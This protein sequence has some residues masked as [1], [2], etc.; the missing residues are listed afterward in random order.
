MFILLNSKAAG[1]N[2]LKKWNAIK[3]QIDI[4][5]A[6][7]HYS[8]GNDS[9]KQE[10]IEAINNGEINFIIAGGDGTINLFINLLISAT[11]P[12]IINEIKIGAIGIGSSNDFH[13]PLNQESMVNN[14]P[15]KINFKNATLRDVGC[16][17]YKSGNHLLK[18][19]FLI[20]ASIGVTAE[21]NYY[22]NSSGFITKALKII[23]TNFAINYSALRAIINN[24]SI[25]LKITDSNNKIKQLEL[26]NLAITK[27][28]HISGDITMDYPYSYQDGLFNI[29]FLDLKSKIELIKLLNRLQS[30]NIDASNV[31]GIIQSPYLFIEAE[32]SFKV[33]FDGEVIITDRA[34]FSIL[35][36]GIRICSN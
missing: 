14:I 21:A 20:N 18:K 27:S 16:I 1:G 24:K 4:G 12:K 17:S 34:E 31:F 5:T 19:Y 7:I 29:Y 10:I 35:Q 32:K 6:T 23:S 15:I 2:A 11:E 33:E 13:K 8:N 36:K 3:N 25:E 22:F 30:K 9:L 28:P 26:A